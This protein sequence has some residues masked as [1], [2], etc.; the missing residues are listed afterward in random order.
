[1]WR[2]PSMRAAQPRRSC[3]HSQRAD[4]VEL[5]SAGVDVLCTSPRVSASYWYIRAIVR[6]SLRR[7]VGTRGVKAGSR[8]RL[9]HPYSSLTVINSHRRQELSWLRFPE[10]S[11]TRSVTLSRSRYM[12]YTTY[13]G[14]PR[15]RLR[16]VQH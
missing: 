8:I 12:P 5:I 6:F 11:R 1:M 14:F 15:E 16:Q 4:T 9:V 3:V 7:Q 2:V 10:R 13:P